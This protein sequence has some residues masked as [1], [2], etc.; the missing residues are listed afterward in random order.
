MKKFTM[1]TLLGSLMLLFILPLSAQELTKSFNESFDVNKNAEVSLWNKFGNTTV[2]TWEKNQVVI[3]VN[4]SVDA[5]SEKETQRIL[6]KISVEIS[7]SNSKVEARTTFDGKLNC[8]NCDFEIEMEVKMPRSV[9]LDLGNEFGN[10][11]VDDLDGKLRADVSYGNLEVNSL[12]SSENDI[13]VN[14]G[15]FEADFIKAGKL[16]MEYS[17]LE[18]TRA[19]YLDLYSRF[20]SVS[21][22][23]VSELI[24]DSQYDDVEIGSVETLDGKSDFSG[25]EIGELM[26]KIVLTSTYGDIEIDRV[27]GGFSSI[28]IDTEFGGVE[29][30]IS[31]SASYKL[32]ARASFGDI[33]FP[34]SNAE[35]IKQIEESFNTE[36]EAFIGSDKNS[37][38]TVKVTAKNCDIEID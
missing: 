24:L 7:G 14:F 5:R 13:E 2:T 23:E 28:D 25:L 38:S 21:I 19:G 35:I 8:K 30:S 33:D 32:H 9:F 3:D 10:A 29:M 6:D 26:D 20:G 37:A 11:Y 18:L 22:D 17:E 31:S 36:V 1:I 12:N 15:S 34:E 4:I 16:E 27:S